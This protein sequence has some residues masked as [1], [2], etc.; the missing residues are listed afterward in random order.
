MKSARETAEEFVRKA[1]LAT[2]MGLLR[3]WLLV[4]EQGAS[5]AG[6]LPAETRALASPP[7]P[8]PAEPKYPCDCCGLLR[9]KAEGGT[10][11]TV[12]DHCWDNCKHGK[13]HVPPEPTPSG[14]HNFS[15][16]VEDFGDRPCRDCAE[17][18]LESVG[19]PTPDTPV[20]T[21]S[22]RLAGSL[23]PHAAWCPAHPLGTSKETKW[24][25]ANFSDYG[26]DLTDCPCLVVHGDWHDFAWTR[27]DAA[28][29]QLDA[30]PSPKKWAPRR[31]RGGTSKDKP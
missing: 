16:C 14:V 15:D 3:R 17:Y 13:P 10:T 27:Q 19:A 23:G 5:V 28:S 25:L 20:C 12:C 11:F 6:T 21:C 22:V 1:K 30:S 24:R 18:A 8:E 2:A 31:W 9:T 26:H 4:W 7:P 29:M